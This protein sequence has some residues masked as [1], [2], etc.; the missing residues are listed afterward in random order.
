MKTFSLPAK[1]CVYFR[2]KTKIDR[3]NRIQNRTSK[4]KEL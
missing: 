3:I 4:I 1:N 2:E